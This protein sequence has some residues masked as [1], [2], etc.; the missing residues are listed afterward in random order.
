MKPSGELDP[1]VVPAGA[2]AAD[3]VEGDA[4]DD[5]PGVAGVGVDGDPAAGAGFAPGLEAGRVERAFQQAAAVQGVADRSRSS[6]SRRIRRSRGRRPRCRGWWRSRWRRRSTSL[7]AC[8]AEAGALASLSVITCASWPGLSGAGIWPSV[9][10]PPSEAICSEITERLSLSALRA[11]AARPA[12][13]G[14]RPVRPSVPGSAPR[15]R[16]GRRRLRA[17]WR[18][19]RRAPLRSSARCSSS[20]STAPR[21]SSRSVFTRLDDRVVVF[22]DLAQVFGLGGHLATSLRIRG[23]RSACPASRPRRSRPGARG[24]RPAPAAASPAPARGALLRL[25]APRWRGPVR[26]A[27]RPVRPRPLPVP[28]AGAETSPSFASIAR[29]CSAIDAVRSLLSARTPSSLS[30]VCFQ[31]L[32]RI[33]RGGFRPGDGQRAGSGQKQRGKDQGT[34]ANRARRGAEQHGGAG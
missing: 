5:H 6:R 22:L 9:A 7:T 19:L 1:G 26:P 29:F 25:P 30:R 4:G 18:R 3:G 14:A 12:L 20:R 33:G 34:A 28:G 21:T 17:P 2:G 11:T 10:S 24:A 31:L 32:L 15:L 13:P 23:S 8:G 16:R 27:F